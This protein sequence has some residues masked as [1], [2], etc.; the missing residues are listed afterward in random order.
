MYSVI[1]C[2]G[3]GS[4][5]WPLSRKNFPKQFLDL[6]SDRSLIQETYSRMRALMPADHIFFITNYESFFNVANQIK[7]MENGDFNE[8][9]IIVEPESLNTAPAIT[10]AVK[11]MEEKFGVGKNEPIA[12]LPSDHY[13]GDREKYLAVLKNAFE[14]VGANIGTIGITPTRPET[15]YGY[16]KK[17]Q[18]KGAYSTVSGFSEKPD[19]ETA[20][21]YLA[22]GAYVW[23][24]G[25]YL[26]TPAAFWRELA[27]HA[28][29]ISKIAAGSLSELLKNFSNLPST[30]ID[31]AISEKSTTM[32]V[33]EGNFG[34]S[35]IGSFENLSEIQGKDNRTRTV[36]VDSDNI[37]AL[38]AGNKLIATVGVKDLV[39]VENTDS[40]LVHR[41]G[42]GQDV[43]KIVDYL[44][45]NKMPELEHNII[46]HRPWGKYEV[47][48]AGSQ[49]QVKKIT[50]YPGAKLSLQS[51]NHRAEHWIVVYGTAQIVNGEK[52]ITLHENESTFIPMG[53]KHRLSNPGKI[54]LEII[55]VQ[56]GS[57]LGEDD[58]I[59]YEDVYNRDKKTSK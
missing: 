58:I 29:E 27:L 46:V 56:T 36:A 6:F 30:S 41:K 3:S 45:E 42:C 51:H 5:L 33:F 38:S 44:K 31:Y 13:I 22:S 12:F 53:N 2:G 55:E 37:Y 43:K 9:Q 7:E 49:H 21:K 40:I 47:L 14:N 1:L 35:D 15:G 17:D 24:G 52:E 28:P 26:F 57:Y 50:V 11:Y 19:K 8:T 23:N 10:L 32:V 59:R 48:I 34:W 20:E 18:D 16:I 54:N 4:R 39:I 25:M